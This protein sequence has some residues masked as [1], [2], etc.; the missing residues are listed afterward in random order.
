MIGDIAQEGVDDGNHDRACL[1]TGARSQV[2]HHDFAVT[3]RKKA[4]VTDSLRRPWLR[5]AWLP[6]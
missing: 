3:P 4:D 1:L 2:H 6:A 5:L